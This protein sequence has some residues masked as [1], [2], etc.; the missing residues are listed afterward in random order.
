M[1]VFSVHWRRPLGLH[2]PPSSP[3]S[4]VMSV[5]VSATCPNSVG[6]SMRGAM[7]DFCCCTPATNKSP[8]LSPRCFPFLEM[9]DW[10][11]VKTSSRKRTAKLQKREMSH[12]PRRHISPG[13]S[14]KNGIFQELKRKAMYFSSILSLLNAQFCAEKMV[15]AHAYPPYTG[16][17]ARRAEGCQSVI[18]PICSTLF[19]GVLLKTAHPPPPPHPPTVNLLTR[20]LEVILV[21]GETSETLGSS[22]MEAVLVFVGW[23]S[24]KLLKTLERV[25]FFFGFVFFPSCCLKSSRWTQL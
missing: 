4:W 17:T 7:S 16:L 21:W 8:T 5:R 3:A 11:T 20:I 6:S 24:I 1:H 15:C 22:N 2:V 18:L 10:W 12:S 13:L 9:M 25:G 14:A 23:S 19:S